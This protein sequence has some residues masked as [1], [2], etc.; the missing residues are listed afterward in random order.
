MVVPLRQVATP[1]HS[2][3]SVAGCCGRKL[4]P[5]FELLSQ[6][7]KSAGNTA[8]LF[9]QIARSRRATIISPSTRCIPR[10]HRPVARRPKMTAR[11]GCDH[12]DGGAPAKTAFIGSKI[13]T[14]APVSWSRC[15]ASEFR[16]L[17]RRESTCAYAQK[18][19]ACRAFRRS[20]SCLPARRSRRTEALASGASP[21]GADERRQF[22][23]RCPEASL[24]MIRTTRRLALRPSCDIVGLRREKI[25]Q[26]ATT[27][28]RRIHAPGGQQVHDAGRA[29]G[30]ESRVDGKRRLDRRLSVWPSTRIWLGKLERWPAAKQRT[31]SAIASRRRWETRFDLYL[32]FGPNPVMA[33]HDHQVGI[34]EAAHGVLDVLTP[35]PAVPWRVDQVQP[36]A[37]C[38]CGAAVAVPAGAPGWGHGPVRW[39]FWPI[40][41]VRSSAYRWNAAT[42]ESEQHAVLAFVDRRDGIH[43]HE[44]RQKQC[45]QVAVGNGPRLM[46]PVFFVAFTWQRAMRIVRASVQVAVQFGFDAARIRRARSRSSPR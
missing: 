38:A 32:H 13:D 36:L 17:P 2:R 20:R 30:G 28:S 42:K 15:A 14:H 46:V 9:H 18:Q 31:A 7:G 35:C 44:E 37:A 6:R 45:H 8:D 27:D 3:G 12:Q 21:A 4:C 10:L 16:R 41:A 19:N 23:R 43:D 39:P 11:S 34:D 40:H 24:T 33:T 25:R 5:G 26:Y 1:V 22:A 29:P